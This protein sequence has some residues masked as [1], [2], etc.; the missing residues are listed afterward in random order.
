MGDELGVDAG[1]ADAARDQLAVLAAEIED[2]NGT[3]LRPGLTGGE[4]QDLS[5]GGNSARPS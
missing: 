3:V 1:L 4:L 2:E 5:L